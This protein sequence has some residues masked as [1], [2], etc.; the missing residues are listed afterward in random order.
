MQFIPAESDISLYCGKIIFE[1]LVDCVLM[2]SYLC[3][4]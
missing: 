3:C 1:E 2:N 4:V